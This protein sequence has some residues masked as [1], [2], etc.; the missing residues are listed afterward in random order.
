MIYFVSVN[1]DG[2]E[3]SREKDISKTFVQ[4]HTSASSK[5]CGPRTG[6]RKGNRSMT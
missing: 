1:N 2:I 4:K 6:N 5:G 3:L